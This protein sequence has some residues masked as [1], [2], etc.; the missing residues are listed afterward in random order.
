M[1]RL[2]ESGIR[3]DHLAA[4]PHCS[5][6]GLARPS[7]ALGDLGACKARDQEEVGGKPPP[8]ELKTEN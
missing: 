4:P 6:V 7:L 2:S 8:G 5:A 3:G 1:I